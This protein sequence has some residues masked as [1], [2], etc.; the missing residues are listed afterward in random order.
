[1]LPPSMHI[2]G[3]LKEMQ[4]ALKNLLLFWVSEPM[5]ETALEM[6]SACAALG[7]KMISKK[8]KNADE[9]ADQ[10]R[11]LQGRPDAIWIP[12]D[13]LLIN[14]QSF[15]ILKGYSWANSVP[16]YVPNEGLVEK[17]ATACVSSSFYEI[18]KTAALAARKAS[19][20]NQT[21]ENYYPES[22]EVFV[23]LKAAK[24]CNLDI[25]AEVLRKAAK[26][27]Q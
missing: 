18:G 7:V 8:L 2:L 12:P 17:G 10:L 15:A 16:F 25:P 13:P 20:E 23:N 19:L 22:L 5:E 6:Q 9:L 27:I 3:K 14:A 4:P 11:S 24:I 1:M 21:P 26:V